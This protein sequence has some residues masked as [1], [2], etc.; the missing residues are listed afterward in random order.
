M[1]CVGSLSEFVKDREVTPNDSQKQE[2]HETQAIEKAISED[3]K[4]REAWI[5]R[6]LELDPVNNRASEPMEALA[7]E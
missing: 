4:K 6:Q 3:P 1:A 2:Y 7:E 5:M